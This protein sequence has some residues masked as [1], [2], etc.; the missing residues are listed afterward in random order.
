MAR[1]LEISRT[2]LFKYCR[3]QETTWFSL[4]SALVPGNEGCVS[5]RFTPRRVLRLIRD[6][7]RGAYDLVVLPAVS[8]G[9]AHDARWAKKLLRRAVGIAAA[10]RLVA[11]V[12]E[13]LLRWKKNVVVFADVSDLPPLSYEVCALVPGFLAYFKR[14]YEPAQT[15]RAGPRWE[16]VN[17]RVVPWSL[18]LPTTEVAP[19][20][21]LKE[22]DVFFAGACNS[23]ARSEGL[24]RLRGLAARGVRVDVPDERLPYR[25][26]MRRMAAAWLV[27]SPS[28]GGWDCYRHY[29]S[30]FAGSVPVIDAPPLGRPRPYDDP[31]EC[32]YYRPEG[33]ALEQTVLRALADKERL[34]AMAARA[35]ARV[36][37]EHTRPALVTRMQATVVERLRQENRPSVLREEWG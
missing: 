3:P 13:L 21:C 18:F 15:L 7:R 16:D 2:P 14:E 4:G 24:P 34:R 33:D 26:F 8:L 35:R 28:G 20:P 36:L 12:L 9:Y 23:A 19:E 37:A 17:R 22:Q 11:A 29:E 5:E 10:S 31:A 25:E 30:A 32:F 6:L 27:W 1:V